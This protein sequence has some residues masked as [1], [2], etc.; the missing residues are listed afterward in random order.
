MTVAL[1]KFISTPTGGHLFETKTLSKLVEIFPTL[2]VNELLYNLEGE[3]AVILNTGANC[4]FVA[5]AG[6]N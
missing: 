1:G 3:D 4:P 6:V 5:L 2:N